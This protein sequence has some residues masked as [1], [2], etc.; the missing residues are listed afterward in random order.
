[1]SEEKKSATPMPP[2][3]KKA[4]AQKKAA[5]E[6]RSRSKHVIVKDVTIVNQK[7]RIRASKYLML[8]LFDDFE[9]YADLGEDEAEEVSLAEQREFYRKIVKMYDVTDGGEDKPSSRER[10]Q[11]GLDNVTLDLEDYLEPAFEVLKALKPKE[12][13][14]P[15]G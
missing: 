3:A 8:D 12:G 9:K 15:L 2:K 7:Y 5:E 11:T 4:A 13:A 1:M 6:R 14:R 10:I